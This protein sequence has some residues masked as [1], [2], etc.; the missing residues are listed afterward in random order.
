MAFLNKTNTGPR[1]C[2]DTLSIDKLTDIES[3]RLIGS[4]ID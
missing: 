4:W 1:V 2:S 3:E